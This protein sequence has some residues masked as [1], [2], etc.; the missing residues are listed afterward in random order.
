MS[1]I[2]SKDN[3]WGNNL[4][5]WIDIQEKQSL[6]GYN[7]V[8]DLIGDTSKN[9]LDV[10]C[11]SGSFCELTFKKGM[12][13][14]GIDIS[15]K[16]IEEASER[17][18]DASFFVGN[19]EKLPFENDAFNIVCGFNSFQY[20]NDLTVALHEAY[21]VLKTNGKIIILIW[22]PKQ[23]CEIATFLK[24]VKSQFPASNS[25]HRDPFCFSDNGTL[26]DAL[27]S[28]SFENIQTNNISSDWK[29]KDVDTALKGILSL[30]ALSDTIEMN[31][32]SKIKEVVLQN[33]T[34]YIQS[35]NSVIFKNTYNI[36]EANKK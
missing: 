33:I 18:K 1:V 14:T 22:G 36:I 8:L 30:G 16:F 17:I 26:K 19:M 15:D 25:L 12:Q 35:D 29:Y 21:R 4:K 31:G 28:S 6:I 32:I 5:D 24:S 2:N 7:Y 34:H 9:I 23:T 27:V 11:G 20:T 10:G 13:V 3:K